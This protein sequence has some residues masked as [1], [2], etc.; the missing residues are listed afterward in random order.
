MAL[1]T[2]CGRSGGILIGI[3][4]SVLELSLIVAGEF[5]I[6][7]H[8]CNKLDKF[9]WILMAVYG[10]AQDDFNPAF[11]AELVRVCQQNPLPTLI[12]GDFNI[13]RS[14]KEKNNDRY[15]DRWP[16]LF[17]AVIDSFDLREIELSGR[18]RRTL[19]LTQPT[20]NCIGLSRQLN[21]SLN[22]H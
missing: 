4:A 15:N 14:S 2:P 17:N 12:G 7:L 11:L 20:R 13:L 6:K 18:H 16:F 22:I 5:Y 1:P 8:L 21:G 9:K 10:L 19:Y 3:N